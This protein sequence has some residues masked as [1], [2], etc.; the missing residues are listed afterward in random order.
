MAS[1]KIIAIGASL[2]AFGVVLGG[3]CWYWGRESPSEPAAP[4]EAS[5]EA[6]SAA[7]SSSSSTGKREL[8]L[9]PSFEVPSARLRSLPTHDE[10]CEVLVGALE[11]L[12]ET[13]SGNTDDFRRACIDVKFDFMSVYPK[14][15]KF[16]TNGLETQAIGTLNGE[17]GKV[18]FDMESI[19]RLQEFFDDD[20][21]SNVLVFL[22][23]LCGH[24]RDLNIAD[25]LSTDEEFAKNLDLA[26]SIAKAIA[27][28]SLLVCV[29][30]GGDYSDKLDT[31]T[32]ADFD[33]SID[34][35][36][37]Y[38]EEHRHI[39]K[40][41]DLDITGEEIV[42][43]LVAANAQDP[44][45]VKLYSVEDAEKFCDI[46]RKA[47]T[48]M[49]LTFIS[50][51][52][53]EPEEFELPSLEKRLNGGAMPNGS[54]ANITGISPKEAAKSSSVFAVQALRRKILANL[55]VS[56]LRDHKQEIAADYANDATTDLSQS[57][58]AE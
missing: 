22:Q 52:E 37:G 50:G 56:L 12:Q 27:L 54:I 57:T 53:E 14:L 46:A 25:I 11:M 21:Y 20:K 13:Y 34:A 28:H 6:T 19:K 26:E 58:N 31:I 17:D 41:A 3:G 51:C 43:A 44:R 32:V 15:N 1:T 42:D 49:S 5:T 38:A 35:A 48:A 45:A 24:H 2:V 36:M 30:L 10:A 47:N 29:N 4:A 9:V 55:V 40:H 33:S 8:G 39:F 7:S 18:I 23:W 16:F